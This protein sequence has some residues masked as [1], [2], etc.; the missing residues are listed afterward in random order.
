MTSGTK[1][2]RL[3]IASQL[4]EGYCESTPKFSKPKNIIGI[5]EDSDPQ[6]K[7]YFETCIFTNTVI[8][9][10]VD[11]YTYKR[12]HKENID[13]DFITLAHDSGYI[14]F[15]RYDASGARFY[16]NPISGKIFAL[17]LGAV[18]EEGIFAEDEDGEYGRHEPDELDD[19]WMQSAAWQSW[20]SFRDFLSQDL[21]KVSDL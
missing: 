12:I 11:L 19:R 16:V 10:N 20:N 18:D 21:S 8:F 9:Q 13:T 4:S 14:E 5:G 17:G 7:E 15:A 1:K 3:L 2:L 6:V